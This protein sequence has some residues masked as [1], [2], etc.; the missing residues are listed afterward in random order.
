MPPGEIFLIF[1][2]LSSKSI[3]SNKAHYVFFTFEIF[4]NFPATGSL[5]DF[6]IFFELNGYFLFTTTT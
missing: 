3:A 1:A 6:E 2:I 4:M 5:Q